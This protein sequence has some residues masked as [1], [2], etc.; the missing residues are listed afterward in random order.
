MPR[1]TYPE[2]LTAALCC[3][4]IAL[5]AVLALMGLVAP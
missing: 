1:L 2:R 5:A 3:F 4:A